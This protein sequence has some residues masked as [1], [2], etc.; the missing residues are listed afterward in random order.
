MSLEPIQEAIG[1]TNV[2][3]CAPDSTRPCQQRFKVHGYRPGDGLQAGDHLKV[4]A[5]PVEG[6]LI[7]EPPDEQIWHILD[8]ERGHIQTSVPKGLQIGIG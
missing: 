1:E 2:D 7:L 3:R 4:K 6:R 5:S 8:R